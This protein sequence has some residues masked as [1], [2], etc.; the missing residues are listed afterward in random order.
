MAK[1]PFV[2]DYFEGVADTGKL[3][4]ATAKT[5]WSNPIFGLDQTGIA[6][7]F[8]ATGE[9]VERAYQHVTVEPEWNILSTEVEGKKVGVALET[10]VE[11]PFGKLTQFIAHR[12]GPA[13]RKVFLAAPLSGHHATLIR[14]TVIGLLPHADVYV[15]EMEKYPGYS[16]VGRQVCY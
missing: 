2:Y 1:T 11:K 9:V 13:P 8:A 4:G 16:N 12:N 3:W 6:N 15:A 5:F 7:L 10:V 14:N